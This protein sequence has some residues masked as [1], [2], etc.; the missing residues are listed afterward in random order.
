MV[1]DGMEHTKA[2]MQVLDWS[3]G[4]DS[5]TCTQYLYNSTFF[6]LGSFI[7][8]M[9]A[10][11]LYWAEFSGMSVCST[12]ASKINHG[13]RCQ[14]EEGL[15]QGHLQT[16]QGDQQGTHVPM[17]PGP[18]DACSTSNS[19]PQMQQTTWQEEGLVQKEHVTWVTSR[20][21]PLFRAPCPILL[22]TPQSESAKQPWDGNGMAAV[23][24][25]SEP[26]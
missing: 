5:G 2:E 20:G 7:C 22:T 10:R 6:K 13:T 16:E 8:G 9:S 3:P 1:Q 18:T 15:G 11:T 17:P 25:A 24:S 12:V 23:G 19:K 26:T 21:K 14:P 4:F